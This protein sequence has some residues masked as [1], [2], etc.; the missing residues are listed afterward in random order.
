MK[1]NKILLSI[2][3][4]YF[5]TLELTKVLADNLLPQLTEEVEWII[6]DDGSNEI[7][8]DKFGVKVIHLKENSGNA[9]IPRNVGLDNAVGDFI[10]FIDSDDLVY[11]NYVETILNKIKEEDFDYC[12]YGWETKDHKYII[13]EE[14]LEWNRCIWNCV[15]KKEIIGDIRFDKKYNIGEDW[16]FN[17]IVRK[18]K[19]ANILDI[20]Y[21]YRWNERD[22]NLSSLYREGK[23]KY[24]RE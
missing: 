1:M 10:A 13:E 22:D 11:S 18:G 19:R 15:Y 24:T 7:E 5:N 8:L 23:I 4:P 3:T 12:Y 14:P 20:L 21:Y 2:I 9:S 6:V 17:K 16:E